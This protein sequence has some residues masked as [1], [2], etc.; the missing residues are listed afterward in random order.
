MMQRTASQDSK[1]QSDF[2]EMRR[3]LGIYVEKGRIAESTAINEESVVAVKPDPQKIKPLKK[4]SGF[5]GHFLAVDCSTR[6]LKRA[7]NWGIYLMRASYAHVQERSIKWDYVERIYTAVGDS[8]A[9]RNLLTNIRIELESQMALNLIQNQAMSFYDEHPDAQRNYL[10]L[11]GAGYFGGDRKYCVSLYDECEKHEISLLALSKNSPLLHD[12]KGRDFVATTSMMAPY[13]LWV[14]PALKKS[15]RDEHL[16]GDIS[17]VKLCETSERVFRC[18]I[19]EYLTSCDVVE[20]LSPL[21]YLS[22]DPRCLGYP[23]PLYLA[24]EFSAP[25]DSMLV[26]HHDQVEQELK[27]TGL[28]NVLRREEQSCSF[29][30]ELHGIRH[31]F[32]WE[33]WDGQF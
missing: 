9:R 5:G 17:V 11:D 25:S 3:K 12:E 7:N 6:T 1:L 28:L 15:N 27:E 32:Q 14:Y 31:A 8:H 2:T 4:I 18:D 19:M 20:T 30:D 13:K 16:Y 33:W 24:H 21:T 22:E 29:A 26:Y 10:L 23:I